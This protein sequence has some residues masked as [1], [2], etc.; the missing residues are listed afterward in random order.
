[1]QSGIAFSYKADPFRKKAEKQHVTDGPCTDREQGV[2]PPQMQYDHDSYAEKLRGK[3]GKLNK[4]DIFQAI[5][6]Q[7][8]HKVPAADRC[9]DK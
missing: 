4:R 5:N 7:N 6:D 1:M 3:G 2:A 8:G 9:P